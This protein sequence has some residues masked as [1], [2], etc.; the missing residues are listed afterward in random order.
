[1]RLQLPRDGRRLSVGVRAEGCVAPRRPLVEIILLGKQRRLRSPNVRFFRRYQRRT[2]LG[3]S[4]CVGV[5]RVIETK[6]CLHLP[7]VHSHGVTMSEVRRG[8][9][10]LVRREH[11][12]LVTGRMGGRAAEQ[13]VR[14][15]HMGHVGVGLTREQVVLRAGRGMAG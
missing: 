10:M 15:R 5:D 3:L 4:D 2:V 14:V 6:C 11:V 1:M 7:G 9:R 12:G 8:V 13:T